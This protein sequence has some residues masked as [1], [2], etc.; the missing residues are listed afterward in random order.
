MHVFLRKK[1]L[2]KITIQFFQGIAMRF[3]DF[4]FYRSF[5]VRATEPDTMPN[6]NQDTC[7]LEDK[8][9]FYVTAISPD[10]ER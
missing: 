1:W 4:K 8:I 9:L 5:A 2:K 10:D 6:E 3:F 7:E